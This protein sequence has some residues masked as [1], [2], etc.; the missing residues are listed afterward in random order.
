MRI[1]DQISVGKEWDPI[2]KRTIAKRAWGLAQVVEHL[3]QRSVPTKK[4][5]K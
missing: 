1:A 4:E 3:L 5:N 2:S